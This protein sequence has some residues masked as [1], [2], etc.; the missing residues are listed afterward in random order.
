[1][2]RTTSFRMA[3]E[4]KAKEI[5]VNDEDVIIMR[6]DS[7][8]NNTNENN[9]KSLYISNGKQHLWMKNV[10]RVIMCHL[11]YKLTSDFS[12]SDTEVVD[13]I[14]TLSVEVSTLTNNNYSFNKCF[15]LQLLWLINEILLPSTLI[16]KHDTILL[17]SPIRW[18]IL[19]SILRSVRR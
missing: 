15:T 9:V 3:L 7:I 14:L 4:I 8:S 1:M 10:T 11:Q 13:F 2:S 12:D 17:S 19:Q 16:L 5:S 18:R 6:V